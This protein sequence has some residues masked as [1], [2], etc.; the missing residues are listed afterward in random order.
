M[1]TAPRSRSSSPVPA[2]FATRR[3]FYAAVVGNVPDADPAAGVDAIM[4]AIDWLHGSGVRL[5]NVSLAG[6]YN[7]ILD[8]GLA[9]AADRGM[10]IVAAVG[11]DGPGAPPRYP[12]AFDFVIAVTAVDAD[13]A[14]Y[15][16]APRGSYVDF[17]APGVDVF[18]PLA[19]SG[20]YMTGTSIAAPFVTA[21]IASSPEAA[22][23][24]RS[25]PSAPASR[26]T[27]S[28]SERRATTTPSAPASPARRSLS[29]LEARR[30]SRAPPD[31][32][33]C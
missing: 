14:A 11:N 21:L 27:P 29:R 26:G 24:A 32:Y 31:R 22:S 2:G 4:R 9:A 7:K 25:R 5:V 6:P 18:V 30:V 1:P 15:A 23:L 28:I 10:V 3:L 19:G 12:A 20:R 17:A 13:L 8:R 33:S 16:R